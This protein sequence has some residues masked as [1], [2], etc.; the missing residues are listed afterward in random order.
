MNNQ[1]ELTQNARRSFMK[2]LLG[3]AAAL[4]LT[5]LTFKAK[6]LNKISGVIP[7]PITNDKANPEEWLGKL[8]GKH[9][10][11]FDVPVA[12]GGLF[13]TYVNNFMD[14]NNETG[15]ADKDLNVVV[16][17]RHY[18]AAFG[19]NDAMWEKYKIGSLVKFN[20]AETKEPAM[21]NVFY[22]PQSG[23]P[24]DK[25]MHHAQKRNVLFC[26]CDRSINAFAEEFSSS[27]K[28]KASDVEKELRE[29]LLPDMQLVPSGV[30]ALGRAQEHGC[31]Y[32]YYG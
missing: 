25:S 22:K 7:A 11:M 30:W 3:G 27:M 24:S 13:L 18:G 10:M 6:A 2:T 8:Q 23:W 12:K 20:D 5:G 32:C 15:T 14:T 4:G 1:T 16:I 29:N 21:R 26:V 28:L 19:F 17:L 31:A 9:K